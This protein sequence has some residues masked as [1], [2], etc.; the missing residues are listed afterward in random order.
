LQRERSKDERRRRSNEMTLDHTLEDQVLPTLLLL[1]LLLPHPVPVSESRS[2]C[3]GSISSQFVSYRSKEISS[4]AAG[5][6]LT[7]C[8]MR[9]EERENELQQT[10]GL[11]RGY[12]ADRKGKRDA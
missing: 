10:Q 3:P 6:S 2:L 7:C 11:H 8:L 5:I 12:N 1:L 4:R 9:F